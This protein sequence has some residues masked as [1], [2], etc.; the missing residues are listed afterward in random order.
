MWHAFWNMSLPGTSKKRLQMKHN[1]LITIAL[2]SIV[3]P[4]LPLSSSL[5][6]PLLG[7]AQ[8]FAVLGYAGVTNDH[9]APNAADQVGNAAD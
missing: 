1:Y 9:S 8:S 7:S 4:F 6:T 2:A 5:A 3:A